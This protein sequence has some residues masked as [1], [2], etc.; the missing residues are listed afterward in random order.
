M[1]KGKIQLRS[2]HLRTIAPTKVIIEAC[3]NITNSNVNETLVVT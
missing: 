2:L 1:L 3:V